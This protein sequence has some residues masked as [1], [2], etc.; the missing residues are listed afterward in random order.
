MGCQISLAHCLEHF[1]SMLLGM[2][3]WKA[4][5]KTGLAYP[6]CLDSW[7]L[8]KCIFLQTNSLDEAQRRVESFFSG[9]KFT[10]HQRKE[11]VAMPDV[12]CK[13]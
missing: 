13:F 2:Q 3:D 1:G 4:W 5:G 12:L 8:N 11:P 6:S 10:L 7:V 9:Q